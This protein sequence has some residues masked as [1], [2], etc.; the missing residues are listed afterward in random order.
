M[1]W[2]FTVLGI[3]YSVYKAT[4]GNENKHPTDLNSVNKRPKIAGIITTK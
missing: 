3:Y 1:F 4:S 2:I